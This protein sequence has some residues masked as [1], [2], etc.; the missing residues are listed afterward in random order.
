MFKTLFTGLLLCLLV[1]NAF[2]QQN[3]QSSNSQ[4]TYQKGVQEQNSVQSQ[5][6]QQPDYQRHWSFGGWFSMSFWNGGT[7]LLIAPKAY[8]HVSPKFL[9]GFGVTY[10]NTYSDDELFIYNSN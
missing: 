7:D 3:N 5:S 1:S 4:Y 2:G 8:Y 10:N 9:N 6:Q